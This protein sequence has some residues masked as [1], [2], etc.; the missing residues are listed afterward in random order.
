MKNLEPALAAGMASQHVS[1]SR[2]QS[3]L[4]FEPALAA[5]MASQ[6]ASKVVSKVYYILNTEQ[7]PSWDRKGAWQITV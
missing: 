3:V 2:E 6:H 4:H 7:V 5:C 1:K